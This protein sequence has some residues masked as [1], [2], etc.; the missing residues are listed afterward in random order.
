MNESS[1]YCISISF[2]PVSI[3]Y[4]PR[5]EGYAGRSDV[6]CAHEKLTDIL[7]TEV[8]FAVPASH[9][10]APLSLTAAQ[11]P[12]L[13]LTG[14]A[15]RAE[16]PCGFPEQSPVY[17]SLRG[18]RPALLTPSGECRVRCGHTPQQ[19]TWS[20]QRGNSWARPGTR[21]GF[22]P[23]ER[24]PRCERRVSGLE[25]TTTR[26]MRAFRGCSGAKPGW[27]TR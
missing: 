26:R 4:V 8:F 9:A 10:H 7:V 20:G 15:G 2:N 18:F 11:G 6:L 12:P 3:L 5:T 22:G 14:E 19:A 16:Q 25:D 21:Q 23:E 17:D 24:Q 1:I 27:G 13:P